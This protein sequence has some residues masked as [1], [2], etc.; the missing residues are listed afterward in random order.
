L[1]GASVPVNPSK[2]ELFVRRFKGRLGGVSKGTYVVASAVVLAI[3]VAPFAG[4]AGE[5]RALLGGTKN[6]QASG[7]RYERETQ[8][9]SNSPTYGTRQSN[10]NIGDGGGAIY[11]C[12]ADPG[13]EACVKA[14]NLRAGRAFE[15]SGGG[16]EIG[17]IRAKNPNARPFATNAGGQDASAFA[18]APQGVKGS[19][20]FN[21]TGSGSITN[22]MNAI[23]GQPYQLVSSNNGNTV[24]NLPFPVQGRV[25][26]VTA[27]ATEGPQPGANCHAN[28]ASTGASQITVRMRNDNGNDC[29]GGF[30]VVIM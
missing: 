7:A 22:A 16:E 18:T 20:T 23:N 2:E 11:G 28:Y 13:R 14:A 24:I 12:R 1:R 26:T 8:I 4:A 10:T 5:G 17:Y 25:I 19:F 27:G 29:S 30:S 21:A 6:P 3:A 9:W 15:F